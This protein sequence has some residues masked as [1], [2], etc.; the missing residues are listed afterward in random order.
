MILTA[1]TSRAAEGL[2]QP[3][4]GA[5][6]A[7]WPEHRPC[8]DL[9]PVLL[10][11]GTEQAQQAGGGRGRVTGQPWVCTPGGGPGAA[12]WLLSCQQSVLWSSRLVGTPRALCLLSPAG[13]APQ[14]PRRTCPQDGGPSEHSP[15]GLPLGSRRDHGHVGCSIRCRPLPGPG[16]WSRSE[17]SRLQVQ[18]RGRAQCCL[19]TAWRVLQD[20]PRQICRIKETGAAEAPC[21][22]LSP[23][24]N[25]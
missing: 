25:P 23:F 7:A 14:S 20:W 12:E 17:Q 4:G 21:L 1:P 2:S 15:H 24:R 9:G 19:S 11:G 10:P 13:R 8:R 16:R 5:S 6:R 18:A 22:P 3:R